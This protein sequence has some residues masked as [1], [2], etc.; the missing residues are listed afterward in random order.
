[1][2]SV[3][4][5]KEAKTMVE[6]MFMCGVL[7]N[8]CGSTKSDSHEVGQVQKDGGQ[9]GATKLERGRR[10]LHDKVRFIWHFFLQHSCLIHPLDFL[11]PI[12][13]FSLRRVLKSQSFT[14]L[15]TFIQAFGN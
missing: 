7:A 12:G 14:I 2:Q 15:P 13:V 5:R 11:L 10:A 4:E 6:C 1:M 8:P 3:N 9:P